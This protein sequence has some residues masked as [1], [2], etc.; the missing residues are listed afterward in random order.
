[1]LNY[2]LNIVHVKIC[3]DCKTK[4]FDHHLTQKSIDQS[5]FKDTEYLSDCK[6]DIECS[7]VKS[8]SAS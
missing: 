3:A 1:M 5:Q 2:I 7:Y 8:E 4:K 6:F